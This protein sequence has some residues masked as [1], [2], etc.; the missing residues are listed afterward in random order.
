VGLAHR[1]LAHDG[2]IYLHRLSVHNTRRWH[3]WIKGRPRACRSNT[4]TA[5]PL[6][7]ISNIHWL[8]IEKS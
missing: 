6:I 2:S 5:P 1:Q 7:W 4:L 8:L 3:L